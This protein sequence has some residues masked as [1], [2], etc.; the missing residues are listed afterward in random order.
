VTGDALGFAW[1]ARRN[2]DVAISRDGRVVTTLRGD[3][4]RKFAAWAATADEAAQQQRMARL[5]GNYRRGNESVA[6][7]HPR[8]GG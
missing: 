1:V 7:N 6:R 2:G 8:R 4:A 3:A 5:T